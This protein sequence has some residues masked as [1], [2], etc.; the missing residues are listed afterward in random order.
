MRAARR[1]WRNFQ[2]A[3]ATAR[4]ARAGARRVV[5]DIV[6]CRT[7]LLGGHLQVC[8]QCGRE[9]PFY[10]SCRNRHCPSAR[11][12]N[13][14]DGSRRRAHLLPV[15][16]FHVVFTV[17]TALHPLLPRRSAG[18]YSLL[19]QAALGALHAVSRRELGATPGTIAVLHTWSQTLLFHPHIHCIVTGGGLSAARDGGSRH[20]RLF[21]TRAGSSRRSSGASSSNASRNHSAQHSADWTRAGTTATPSG[22]CKEWVVYSKAPMAGQNRCCTIW[23]LHPSHRHR[24]RT[25]RRARKRPGHLPLSRSTTRQPEPAAHSRGARLRTPIPAPR[26]ASWFRPGPPLR[27]AGQRLSWSAARP[28]QTAPELPSL[29]YPTKVL[30]ARGV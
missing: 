20:V 2:S 5:R 11:A 18:S 17:P 28:R 1:S 10:N 13:R 29:S 7:P 8:D 16:Y 14:H 24:Q 25:P 21:G 27:P 12:W 30:T 6:N 23:P 9:K 19:F 4:A 26:A 22:G 15:P 3:C